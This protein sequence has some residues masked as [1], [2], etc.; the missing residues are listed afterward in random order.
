MW[1]WTT[2]PVSW[3]SGRL[4]WWFNP[5][6]G[7]TDMSKYFLCSAPAHTEWWLVLGVIICNLYPIMDYGL[8]NTPVWTLAAQ[9]PSQVFISSFSSCGEN[10]KPRRAHNNFSCRFLC[11]RVQ[12]C[13]APHRLGAHLSHWL[14]MSLPHYARPVTFW[15]QAWL[16]IMCPPQY[17]HLRRHESRHKCGL[18]TT[19]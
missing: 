14:Q 13:V 3:P 7:F 12:R 5:A 8:A 16:I 9:L 2:Q 6:R 1:F 11:C 15:I 4:K 17:D 18:S 10:T 19:N